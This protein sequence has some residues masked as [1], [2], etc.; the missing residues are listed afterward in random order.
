MI[1]LELE[2]FGYIIFIPNSSFLYKYFGIG[3]LLNELNK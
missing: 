2:F 3:H 1:D